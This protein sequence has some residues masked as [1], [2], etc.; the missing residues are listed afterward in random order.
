MKYY[1]LDEDIIEFANDIIKDI[2]SLKYLDK[3][4]PELNLSCEV[5]FVDDTG[6]QHTSKRYGISNAN[7]I[8]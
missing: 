5:V 6:N 7:L 8:K 2:L 3:I 4:W 1:R